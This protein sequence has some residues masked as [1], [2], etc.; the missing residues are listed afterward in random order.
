V[1]DKLEVALDHDEVIKPHDLKELKKVVVTLKTV[2]RDDNVYAEAQSMIRRATP[3][4]KGAQAW[5]KAN[6][7]KDLLDKAGDKISE[8]FGTDEES[9]KLAIAE[10]LMLVGPAANVI[11]QQISKAII[12]PKSLK[13]LEQIVKV[14]KTAVN[15]DEN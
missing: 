14:L 7:D 11:E 12:D 5:L 2:T 15:S 10:N 4:I 13:E 3:I 6:G 8:L 1:V 9:R